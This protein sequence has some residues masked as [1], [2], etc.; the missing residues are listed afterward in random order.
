[1]APS[2][3]RSTTVTPMMIPWALS[4]C[5]NTPGGEP[6]TTAPPVPELLPPLEELLL[7]VDDG[8]EPV[9]VLDLEVVELE[10]DDETK[11]FSSEEIEALERST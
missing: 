1:M 3:K 7:D 2:G 6:T 5:A 9:A 8:D 4:Y 11:G 10:E